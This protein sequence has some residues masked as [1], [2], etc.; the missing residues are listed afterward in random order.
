MVSKDVEMNSLEK[1]SE[2]KDVSPSKSED[3]KPAR[4]MA[5]FAQVRFFLP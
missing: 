4:K 2:L 3:Q 1:S 5:S